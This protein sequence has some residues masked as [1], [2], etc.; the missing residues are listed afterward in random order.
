MNDYLCF[1]YTSHYNWEWILKE[2]VKEIE[3]ECQSNSPCDEKPKLFHYC[4]KFADL[5]SVQCAKASGD[6]LKAEY[7][8]FRI[9]LFRSSEEMLK[10]EDFFPLIRGTSPV[11]QRTDAKDL[12]YYKAALQFN[13]NISTT[14]AHRS[15]H[16]LP[17]TILIPWNVLEETEGADSR[18]ILQSFIPVFPSYP[19]VLKAPMGSGGFGIYFVYHIDDIIEI[20]KNHLLR[21]KNVDKFIEK[22]EKL[23]QNEEISLSWSLQEF[24]QPIKSILPIE[25]GCSEPQRTQVRA[26]IIECE[27]QFFLYKDYEVRC[28]CWDLPLEETL[29]EEQE[30]YS[31][32]ENRQNERIGH[33]DDPIEDECCGRN[34][35]GRPYNEKR[36]KK[37]TYRF[38]ISELSEL[39]STIPV[40]T[41]T[42]I[43]C[44][45]DLKA[46]LLRE[47]Q[48]EEELKKVSKDS[49]FPSVTFAVIGID[50]LV[51]KNVMGDFEV[52]IVEVNNNPAMPQEGKLMSQLYLRHLIELQKSF[53]SLTLSQSMKKKP[54]TFADLFV[55]W[56][57]TSDRLGN[58][59]TV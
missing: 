49:S 15:C 6:K 55:S 25:G 3:D 7:S 28:P 41:K 16:Y 46:L 10:Y 40:I 51:S 45:V 56:N 13:K 23:Y 19:S 9:D 20:M 18:E 53:V 30:K 57:F 36:N 37:L 12:F 11:F 59:I 8:I 52:K 33:W 1:H 4:E 38:M 43:D 48:E 27:S 35:Y 31:N 26:Y 50:L 47:K 22:I 24:I 42:L 39:E 5:P 54:D 14:D 29:K 2:A 58:F 17:K 44:F 32:E 34:G 21:A